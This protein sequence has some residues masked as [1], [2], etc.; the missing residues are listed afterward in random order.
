MTL[1]VSTKMLLEFS[2][3]TILARDWRIVMLAEEKSSMVTFADLYLKI[4]DH[5]LDPLE[6]FIVPADERS[7]PIRVQ[8]GKTPGDGSFQDVPLAVKVKDAVAVFGMYIKFFVKYENHQSSSVSSIVSVGGQRNAA[9]VSNI[10]G[11][12]RNEVYEYVASDRC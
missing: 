2:S 1:L 9:E 3:R 12:C 4:V 8:I 7:A 6:P 10:M 5:S 11:D